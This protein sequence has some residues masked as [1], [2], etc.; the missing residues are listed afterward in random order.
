MGALV[1]FLLGAATGAG[2]TYVLDPDM[3][4][5]RR[6]QAVDKVRGTAHSAQDEVSG[7]LDQAT[8]K[9]MG[10]VAESLPDSPPANEQTLVAK[11]RSEVLGDPRW[12][13]RT[14]NVEASGGTVTL[15]GEVDDEKQR[16][17]LVE[18]VEGV[19]GVDAVESLLHLPGEDP[20]N[21]SAPRAA[22]DP[23]PPTA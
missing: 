18:A 10:S 21:V 5:A 7:R 20:P 6:K 15:R 22:S 3:G 2:I 16:D 14:I 8:D 19:S 1:P 13:G 17:A 23:R 9:L 12:Q 11:V 4:A